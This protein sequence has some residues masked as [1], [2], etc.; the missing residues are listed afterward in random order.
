MRLI[1]M[2]TGPFAVP[3]FR[4]L[5]AS[6]HQVAALVTR[7]VPAARGRRKGP[8]NP[9]RDAFAASGLPLFDPVDVNDPAC[10]PHLRAWNP[11]LFVVCDYG[12]ILSDQTLQIAARGGI[13]L[14]ASL[15]PKYR[16]AAP[17]NWA[18]WQGETHTGVTVI[19]MTP[20]L[21]GGPCLTSACT[22][23][24]PTEDAPALE[25]RLSELG[26]PAV[27]KALDML[28]AWDGRSAL[29]TPQDPA[30]ATRA[31]RLQKSH[32]EV[33]WTQTA[34]RIV[35]QVRALR[36]WPGTYTHYLSGDE[37]MRLILE[38]VTIDQ[39]PVYLP[40]GQVLHVDSRVIVVATGDQGLAIHQLQP[41][42]KRVMDTSEF[43]RGHAVRV[44][45]RLG[46][47]G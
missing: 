34:A 37:P 23:I 35:N 40:A 5:L 45:D 12:Q 31:P 47:G 27:L 3:T 30:Q 13:N 4:A 22:A 42:G 43:L 44:G 11:D 14:H 21:D 10:W 15:L 2:G 46:A 6:R 25:R 26:V 28:E 33:D 19:H 8:I 38:R 1:L 41:A 29:G 9:V 36:P 17:I 24:G 20:R 39:L 32:G 7:P 18:I 16:G